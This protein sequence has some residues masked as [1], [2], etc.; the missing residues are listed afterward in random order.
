[1]TGQ[2]EPLEPCCLCGH[3]QHHEQLLPLPEGGWRC[4]DRDACII[5]RAYADNPSLA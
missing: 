1:M 4:Q 5:R 3:A 2:P